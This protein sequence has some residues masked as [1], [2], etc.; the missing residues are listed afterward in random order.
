M[1]SERVSDIL[2]R[3]CCTIGWHRTKE[4]TT[5]TG[6]RMIIVTVCLDCG[7]EVKEVQIRLI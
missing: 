6:A 7:K 3:L 1:W 2:S 4:F 5:Y